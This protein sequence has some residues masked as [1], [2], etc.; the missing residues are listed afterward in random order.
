MLARYCALA[1]AALAVSVEAQRWGRPH[2]DRY[3]A[4]IRNNYSPR[5]RSDYRRNDFRYAPDSRYYRSNNE[6]RYDP[7]Y[8]RFD[9]R[10][11]YR[12]Q[13][14]RYSNHSNR[15]SGYLGNNFVNSRVGPVK[16]NNNIS[17][18]NHAK[19][20]GNSQNSNQAVQNYVTPF[21][22]NRQGRW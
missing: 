22:G 11:D 2:Y 13:R 1:L 14:N 5:Y 21:T 7:T 4:D 3:D 16:N 15:N 18:R 19:V 17:A 6:Y 9:N 8:K 12:S 20:S 10:Q